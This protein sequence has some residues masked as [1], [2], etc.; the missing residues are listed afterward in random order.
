MRTIEDELSAYGGGLDEKP[1]LVALNKVDLAD[2]ELAEAFAG[3]LKAA[4]AEDV[5]PISGVT[6]EGI[7]T[8][9][10]KVISFL[11]VATVTERPE[12]EREEADDK[13]WSPI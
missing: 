6:G 9:L 3:E 10:D 5:Y 8:L 4:G 2:A 1:R 12:G 13:P 11:P 7:D